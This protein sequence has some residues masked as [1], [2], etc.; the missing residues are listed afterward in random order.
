MT[1]EP[2]ADL[3]A[4][5][6]ASAA[7]G[8]P[9]DDVALAN[10]ATETGVDDATA[11]LDNLSTTQDAPPNPPVCT[12]C[13]HGSCTQFGCSCDVG[14]SGMVCDMATPVLVPGMPASATVTRGRWAYFS[15]EGLAS[16]VSATVTEDSTVGLVWAYLG[17]GSAPDQAS[18]LAAN[19]DTQ[20]ATH[21]VSRTFSGP[22][23]QVW[24]VGAYGQP[25]IPATTQVVAFHVTITVI[26]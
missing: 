21:T 17:A 23:T 15:F 6:D 8:G 3:D 14:W 7:D 2:S 12:A 26:P 19:E 25:G 18:H 1:D 11:M 4:S 16:G 9:L 22:G 24:Y 20:S 5:P 10:D 13:G